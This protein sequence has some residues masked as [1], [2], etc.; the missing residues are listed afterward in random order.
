MHIHIVYEWN[1]LTI[2]GVQY[3]HVC[4]H[5]HLGDGEDNVRGGGE[6]RQRA[7]DAVAHHLGKHH[8]HSLAQ[9]HSFSLNA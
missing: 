5:W 6:R 8:G 3:E 2:D 9:H 1:F 7:S 4:E